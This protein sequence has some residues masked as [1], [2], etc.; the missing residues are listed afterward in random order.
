ML[1]QRIT[2]VQLQSELGRLGYSVTERALVDWRAKGLL[3]ALM[4]RGRGRGRGKELFW[5]S[6]RIV[7]QGVVVCQL[8]AKKY[9]NDEA[10]LFLWFLGFP[11]KASGVRAAWLSRLGK[12]ELNLAGKRNNALSRRKSAFL[13]PE[14]EIS[15]LT[16]PYLKKIAAHFRY[17]RCEIAQPIIDLFGLTFRHGYCVDENMI[18]GLLVLF[19]L[20]AGSKINVNALV[21]APVVRI[22][23]QSVR[24]WCSFQA[25]SAIVSSATELELVHSHRRWRK[26][27]RLCQ[28]AFPQLVTD[29]Q[30]GKFLAAGLGR[31]LVPTLIRFIREGKTSK[32]D[33]SIP[34]IAEFIS[35]HELVGIIE[36]AV[37]N[38]QMAEVDKLELSR[39]VRTLSII[40]DHKGFPF[41]LAIG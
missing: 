36:R 31:I 5:R 35:K 9:P 12:V 23:S 4:S 1:P 19:P 15:V 6:P 18:D 8:L 11:V 24:D 39:L 30:F 40:W 10:R 26:L 13:D 33:K 20:L 17:D 32:I 34:E 14:D 21:S 22:V 3:P 38:N 25:I 37:L 27:V 41:S 29:Q 7:E 28:S 2:V 16:A